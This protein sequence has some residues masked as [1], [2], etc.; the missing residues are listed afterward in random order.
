MEY[1]RKIKNNKEPQKNRR[2][3]ESPT[4][5]SSLMNDQHARVATM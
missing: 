4:L 3:A 2:K 1:I 5:S